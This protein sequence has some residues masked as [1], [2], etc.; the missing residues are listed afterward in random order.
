MPGQGGQDSD[1][2]GGPWWTTR[3]DLH[4]LYVAEG[5]HAGVEGVQHLGWGD[6]TLTDME[7]HG[8]PLELTFIFSMLQRATMLALRAYST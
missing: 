8:G 1:R 2:P 6:G 3:T 5:N 4:F 7:G